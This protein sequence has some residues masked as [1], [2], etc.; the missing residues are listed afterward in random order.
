VG[1][2]CVGMVE[3]CG[4]VCGGM[5]HSSGRVVT[6]REWN[7]RRNPPDKG[8]RQC[9]IAN[10]RVPG[11]RGSNMNT[12]M[13]YTNA[14]GIA[15]IY[16]IQVPNGTHPAPKTRGQVIRNQEANGGI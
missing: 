13:A 9:P 11:K 3:G 15:P 1:K 6:A 8:M 5:P 7:H 16:G 10:G 12:S 2:A 4:A 14:I